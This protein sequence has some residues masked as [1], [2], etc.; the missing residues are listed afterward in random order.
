MVDVGL[1]QHVT[2][3]LRR[4]EKVAKNAAKDNIPLLFYTE[5]YG[6]VKRVGGGRSYV[7]EALS[8]QNDSVNWVGA[9][10]RASLVEN[11]VL[12]AAEF[13]WYYM[14][15]SLSMTR[16]EMY[17]NSGAEQV[18]SLLASKSKVLESTQQNKLHEGLNS[19]GTGVG[20]LQLAG[21]PALVSTTP[22]T[23]IVGGIARTSSDAAWFRNQKF[24]TSGDWSDGAVDSGNVTRFL[25][26]GLDATTY[27]S[28]PQVNV[29]FLGDT[30][31][32]ALASATRAYQQIV[33]EK[34]T[35]RIGHNKIYYRGVPM[36]LSGGLNYSGFTAQTVT[37]TR[38]LNVEEG[39]FNIIF[40]KKAEFSLL[41]PVD[42]ADQAAMSRLMFTMVTASIGGHA[43][44]CWVG[45]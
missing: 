17:Q 12:D 27:N 4:R 5:K 10:G 35:A 30:H 32:K 26:Q 13:Q 29:G 15:G 14:L 1:G 37:Q 22:T 39:G 19:N 2:A 34:D 8:D 16:A 25:D 21:L 9:S 31:W 18:I 40:H 44:K 24:D 42:S 11:N 7:T 28:E 6:G 20:G 36:I 41:E 3:T 43:K 38:L 23:G 45:F 33:H